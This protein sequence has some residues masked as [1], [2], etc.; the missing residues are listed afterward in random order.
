M[1]GGG[2]EEDV[3]GGSSLNI[4]YSLIVHKEDV[5]KS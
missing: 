1:L 4:K 3:G 2:E 5:Y